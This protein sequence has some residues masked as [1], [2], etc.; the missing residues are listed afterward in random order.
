[1]T[2]NIFSLTWLFT[3]NDTQS[4]SFAFKP[5]PFKSHHLGRS[6]LHFDDNLL[7]NLIMDFIEHITNHLLQLVNGDWHGLV[8]LALLHS[9]QEE[10]KGIH[11]RTAGARSTPAWP[12]GP[13]LCCQTFLP[14]SQCGPGG[15]LLHTVARCP[16]WT[17]PSPASSW[18]GARPCG[19][20]TTCRHIGL[21][22]KTIFWFL[23]YA[24][25]CCLL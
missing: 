13:A 16:G 2:S 8:D 1:M 22:T 17:S 12:S 25:I 9:P 7:D 4:D 21:E 15:A 11:V 23:S 20:A 5:F 10:I 3:A 19:P 24:N 14:A 18:W 6:G